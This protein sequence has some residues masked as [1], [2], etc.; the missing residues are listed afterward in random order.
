MKPDKRALDALHA[1][2]E[3]NGTPADVLSRVAAKML[4]A[5]R[6]V[7]QPAG[8]ELPLGTTRVGGR[9]DLP[10]GA[11]WPRCRRADAPFRF[12][13]QVNLAEVAPFDVAGVL[14]P[15]GLLSFFYASNPDDWPGD[16]AFLALSGIDRLRRLAWP[17]ALPERHR[18]RPLALR[19]CVEWTLASI[20]DTGFDDPEGDFPHY[21]FFREAESDVAAA[22]GLPTAN[23]GNVSA[24]RLLGHPK[25]IQSP[26]LADGTRL[27]LQADADPAESL[28]P[29][30]PRTGMTWGSG[31][32][33]YFLI[34][35]EALAGR[36]LEEEPWV[37]WEG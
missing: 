37:T 4:P 12:V 9:P 11:R 32:R 10:A 3:R 21:A 28:G 14:P 30:L 33:L 25:M 18:Y 36:R 1:V 17:R 7:P 20:E 15:A 8:D 16:Y 5:V 13:M 23:G 27:L 29:D 26:G 24:H 31:G 2:A 19:P 35:E 22:Q 34:D 6:L